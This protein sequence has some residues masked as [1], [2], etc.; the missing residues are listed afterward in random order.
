MSRLTNFKQLQK[1]LKNDIHAKLQSIMS[2]LIPGSLITVAVSD[3]I[4]EFIFTIVMENKISKT[5]V[6]ITENI[7]TYNINDP[8]NLI[9]KGSGKILIYK[10]KENKDEAFNSATLYSLA[11][12]NA[13]IDLRTLYSLRNRLKDFANKEGLLP[14][15]TITRETVDDTTV[16]DIKEIKE[17]DL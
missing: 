15:E 16:P 12:T 6:T 4:E 5:T 17:E 3:D 10:A 11:S 9:F 8:D 2:Q 14:E 7:L 13:E 1:E